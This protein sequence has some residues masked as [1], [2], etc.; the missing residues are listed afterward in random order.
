MDVLL[1]KGLLQEMGAMCRILDEIHEDIMFLVAAITNDEITARH[2]RYL[3]GFWA[4]EFPDPNNTMAR[5]EKPAMPPRRKIR[6]YV[7]SV[8][9][10]DP[11]L[12]LVA[13][14][15]ETVSSTYS[16]YVH[17][18]AVQAMDLYGGFPPHFYLEGMLGTPLMADHVYD[19]W[20][21]Y[22]RG[23]CSAVVVAKAFGHVSMVDALKQYINRFLEQSGDR[24]KDELKRPSASGSLDKQD[25]DS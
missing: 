5:H 1:S 18:R 24:A 15:G 7:T 4:E 21:Y 17:A 13:D 14:V 8:L 22:Y 12:S 11:N 2:K 10:P 19:A 25:V 20:N 3:A 16:G 9:N 6:S 23:V